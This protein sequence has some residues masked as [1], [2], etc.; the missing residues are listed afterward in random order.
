LKK[1]IEYG[2]EYENNKM[3]TFHCVNHYVFEMAHNHKA[4]LRERAH[5]REKKVKQKKKKTFLGNHNRSN[6]AAGTETENPASLFC[7]RR[8]H[9][10][11]DL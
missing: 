1:I 4:D 6:T 2:V 11:R 8:C 9:K 5:N 10:A 3:L 7:H